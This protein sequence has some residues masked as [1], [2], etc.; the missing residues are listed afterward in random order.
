MSNDRTGDS[1]AVILPVM[2]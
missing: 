2:R 1:A